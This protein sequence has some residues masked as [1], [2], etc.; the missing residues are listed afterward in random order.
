MPTQN[1]KIAGK[2]SIFVIDDEV[3]L[4]HSIR[5][6]LRRKG[7][8]VSTATSGKEAL[9]KIIKSN[10]NNKPFDL[11]ITDLQ[12]PGLTGKEIIESLKGINIST[13]ILVIT[14][15]GTGS[16][17][18]EICCGGCCDILDKPFDAEVLAKRVSKI[19]KGKGK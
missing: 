19:L 7:Y 11:I 10:K 6:T 17:K 2:K 12:L 15:H 9:N 16:L 13:P 4:L 5:F 14:A 1:E 8:R 3:N 18:K